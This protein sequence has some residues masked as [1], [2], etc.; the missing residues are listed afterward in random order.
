MC[1][2]YY[3]QEE[4]RIAK[5]HMLAESPELSE[6]QLISYRLAF[7]SNLFRKRFALL[8]R[9]LAVTKTVEMRDTISIVALA[10]VDL[11]GSKLARYRHYPQRYCTPRTHSRPAASCLACTIVSNVRLED[12]VGQSTVSRRYHGSHRPCHA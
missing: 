6:E 10:L 5:T 12:R 2:L 9:V 1:S 3:R 7:T 11:V 4:K 8:R